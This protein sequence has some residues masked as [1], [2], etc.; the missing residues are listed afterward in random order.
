M[1]RPLASTDI[2]RIVD[3]F[4]LQ[5]EQAQ[6]SFVLLYPEGM[7]RLSESAGEIVRR[8][9]GESSIGDIIKSL[10][11]AFPGV[12]LRDDVIEFVNTAHE[13]GWIETCLW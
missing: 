7:V 2:L 3:R 6:N 12:E 1:K 5:W 11:E 10:E 4:R 13:R 8:I 9:D